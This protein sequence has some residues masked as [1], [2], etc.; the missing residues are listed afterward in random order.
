MEETRRQ[1]YRVGLITLVAL[2]L[3][4]LGVTWGR[5]VRIGPGTGELLRLRFPEV[6]GLEP[7][8]PVFVAGVRRGSVVALEPD[9]TS[10]VVV[11]QLERGI[12]LRRDAFARIGLQEL[13]GGRKVDLFPGTAAEPLPEGREIPG[14]TTPDVAE[15]LGRLGE[16][17]GQIQRAISRLDTAAAALTAILTPESRRALQQSIQNVSVLSQRLREFTEQHQAALGQTAENVAMLSAELRQL[18]TT[19]RPVVESTL[20]RLQ[21]TSVAAEQTLGRADSLVLE[22]RGATQRLV[23]I[24]QE[25]QTGKSL[26]ARLLTDDTLAHQVDSTLVLLR[27][28]VEQVRRYGINVNVRL[29]TRP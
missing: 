29:G 15:L 3:F 4:L 18:L 22:L 5:G 11:V 10:V 6:A 28:F 8:A 23:P 2:A 7:G 27:E 12:A 14:R 19:Q 1:E 16:L 24:L 21:Y 17:S 9:S 26:A 20:Q 13:T 25:L